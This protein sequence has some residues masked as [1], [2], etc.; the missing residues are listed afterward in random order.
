MKHYGNVKYVELH[1]LGISY[2]QQYAWD[3][4]SILR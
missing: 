3:Y 4:I 2:L 1:G